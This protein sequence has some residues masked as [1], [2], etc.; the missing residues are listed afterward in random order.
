M[1]KE[2]DYLLKI[3]LVGDSDV[4]KSEILSCVEQSNL[5]NSE[6]SEGKLNNLILHCKSL[7]TLPFQQLTRLQ[8]SYLTAN[9]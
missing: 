9:E 3:L 1:A 2:Y 6:N 4:G 7:I 5:E 8:S